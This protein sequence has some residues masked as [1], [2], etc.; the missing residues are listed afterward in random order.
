MNGEAGWENES[1]AMNKTDNEKQEA[2]GGAV[3]E[4]P[5]VKEDGKA[6]GALV[7][8][9]AGSF[10]EEGLDEALARASGLW[11]AAVLEAERGDGGRTVILPADRREISAGT[12]SSIIRRSGLDRLLF[13][14]AKRG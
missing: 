7:G 4:G 14:G 12:V 8:L 9:S 11:G 13:R 6:S 1:K 10:A 5:G 3:A 2:A